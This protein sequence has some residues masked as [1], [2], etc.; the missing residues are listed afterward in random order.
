MSNRKSTKKDTGGLE[1][2]GAFSNDGFV[3]DE[4]PPVGNSEREIE[5]YRRST[6]KKTISANRFFNKA[7]E[8]E[9]EDDGVAE[10]QSRRLSM[11][12]KKRKAYHRQHCAKRKFRDSQNHDAAPTKKK[13]SSKKRMPR[14]EYGHR[15]ERAFS[16]SSESNTSHTELQGIDH[17]E[18][19]SSMPWYS[20]CSI[21]LQQMLAAAVE[22]LINTKEAFVIRMC[23]SFLDDSADQP[24]WDTLPSDCHSIGVLV[25]ALKGNIDMLKY[26]LGL[27]GD[28]NAIDLLNRTALHYAASS[29]SSNAPQCIE[30]LIEHG[31]AVDVWDRNEEATPLI[32]AAASGR[33]ELVEVLLN[34]GAEVNAGLSDPKHLDGSSPLL[35]AIRARSLV[36]AT[37]LIKAGAAVNS[38]QVY[39]ESPIH[40]AAVQGDVQWYYYYNY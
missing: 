31:A 35:W 18:N 39:T 6:I 38:L 36:C 2:S 1:E 28:A 12:K 30:L 33:I 11:D 21:W 29:S 17:H 32:C 5:K 40:V 19:F 4:G 37:R 8:D 3:K 25:S 15:L 26:F 23:K 20:G 16:I 10:D 24:A 14:D 22:D 13:Q 9:N 7:I 27:G 34:A